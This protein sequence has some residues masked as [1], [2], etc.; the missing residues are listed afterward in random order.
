MAAPDIPPHTSPI[1]TPKQLVIVVLLAFIVPITII[2]AL[3]YL[4]TS[5]PRPDP[6][7]V[8]LSPEKVAERIRPVAEVTIG[9]A[10]GSQAAKSGDEVYKTVCQACHAAG[11]QGA[12]KFGN[13][14]DWGPRIKRGEKA[15]LQSALKGKGA[16]PPKG[17]AADLSDVEIE[18]ALVYMANAAGAGFKEPA[19]PAQ[20]AAPAPQTAQAQPAPA[21]DA[22]GHDHDHGAP[23]APAPAAPAAKATPA[24]AKAD[25]KKVFQGTCV[26]C[27]GTGVAGAPKFGDKAAWAPHLAHG[28]D[29]LYHSALTGK[30]AMP[31]KG[32]NMTL[33]DDEVKAAVDYM[34]GAVK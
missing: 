12:P 15:L 31:P 11:I 32:G 9:S 30:N 26:V 14:G 8:A 6:D 34:V 17:G 7:S 1:R 18:R 4:V 20:N 29:E 25:G 10:R 13:R 21:A 24:S 33:S 22:A 19:A 28:K 5:G 2:L 23:T 27:H 3:A 16:M